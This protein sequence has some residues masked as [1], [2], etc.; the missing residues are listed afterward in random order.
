MP[1]PTPGIATP[2]SAG[3]AAA[4]RLADDGRRDM[5]RYSW[6]L[7][8][9]APMAREYRG[10]TSVSTVRSCERLHKVAHGGLRPPRGLAPVRLQ[11]SGSR[12]PAQAPSRRASP[13]GSGKKRGAQA[14][15]ADAPEVVLDTVDEDHRDHVRVL[16]QISRRATDIAILEANAELGG[17]VGNDRSRLIT[18]VT[19]RAGEHRDPGGRAHRY[20]RE[21]LPGCAD[22]RPK[23]RR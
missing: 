18:Q 14:G 8:L 5:R 19:P 21:P 23:S 4:G 15:R 13:T 22:V 17:H 9:A 16:G 12:R 1:W 6:G 10:A 3:L 2:A 20:S 11:N 7:D